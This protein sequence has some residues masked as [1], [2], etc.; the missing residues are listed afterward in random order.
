MA[1]AATPRRRCRAAPTPISST[2]SSRRRG[3]TGGRRRP[4]CR[5]RLPARPRA[6]PRPSPRDTP[7]PRT[8]RSADAALHRHGSRRRT[9][10]DHQ[11][12]DTTATDSARHASG[13]V[14]PTMRQSG[15]WKLDAPYR[16]RSRGRRH[17]G[18]DRACRRGRRTGEGSSRTHEPTRCPPTTLAWP[19]RRRSW[20]ESAPHAVVPRHRGHS[21]DHVQLRRP[22][23]RSA[24]PGARGTGPDPRAAGGLRRPRRLFVRAYAAGSPTP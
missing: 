8:Q 15:G 13:A 22:A 5:A 19:A 20:Q 6:T 23:D 17:R 18:I 1:A 24:G 12:V 14:R 10:S 7:P 16:S 21:G 4:A 2:T 3:A 9:G 11:N